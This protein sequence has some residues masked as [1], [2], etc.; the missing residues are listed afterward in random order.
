MTNLNIAEK[1]IIFAILIA[2]MEADGI[3]DPYETEFL[4][5]IFASF[6]M[7]DTDLDSIDELDI[8][9]TI[10]EFRLFSTDKKDYAI[11]I[12]MDMAK[13]DGFVDPRE[14]KIIDTLRNL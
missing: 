2:I 9:E 1:R 3:I 12:F 10:N 13:C 8:T 5:N 4:D 6:G 7:K 11:D 14:M